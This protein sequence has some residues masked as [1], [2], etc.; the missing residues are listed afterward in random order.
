ML[1]LESLIYDL[2]ED[3]LKR[4]WAGD[5]AG[6]IELIDALLQKELPQCLRDRLMVERR[7]AQ[8]LPK[9]FCIP[10][11]RAFKMVREKIP[12]FS[13]EEL[14]AL[15]LDRAIEYIYVR[16]EKYY[17]RSFLSTLL[18]VHPDLARRAGMEPEQS[19][20]LDEAI[21]AL[22]REGELV[23]DI[24]LRGTLRISDSA[25]HP[26]GRA[27]VYLPLPQRC[28][29]QSDTQIQPGA[30]F[31]A[32]ERAPQRTAYF[33]RLMGENEPFCVEY[34][35]RNAVRY[36]DL[37]GGERPD[38]PVYPDAAPPC[39]DDLA[40]QLP[41]IAFTPLIRAIANEWKGDETDP[42]RIA[43]RFYDAITSRIRYS[44]MRSY[45]L[46]D[47][48]AEFCALNGKG[49]CGIQ[50]LLFIALCR[51]AGIPARWQSGLAVS[52]KH[53]GCHDWA[54]F[55]VEPYGWLFCDPSY[56]GSAHRAGDEARRRF[57]FGNLDPFRMVANSRYQSGFNPPASFDRADPYDNQE[58]EVEFDG[59][60]LAGDQFSTVYDTLELKKIIH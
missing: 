11:S 45:S 17:L 39:A 7:V 54:Q 57:Y 28:A 10:R 6:E 51:C 20:E 56:G 31:M 29:Q 22:R 59:I 1:N 15:E 8:M 26:G 38:A 47:R 23:Y 40:E 52:R 16:G 50:A 5:F 27:R 9:Q 24:R 12:D 60:G 14:D 53:A 33:D 49:D 36:V 13:E 35:Y 46:I 3:V 58:G 2:P 19:P 41:H 4:K 34:S 30:F 18:H 55:Y 44:Y 43:W 42:I 37:L 48:Q 21:A 32:D 25:F